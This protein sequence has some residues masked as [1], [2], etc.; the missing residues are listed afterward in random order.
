MIAMPTPNT[1]RWTIE[2]QMDYPLIGEIVPSPD[3]R[4]VLA[5]IREPLMSDDRSEFLTHLYLAGGEGRLRQLTF[6]DQSSY[7]PRWSPDGQHI[8]FV[9][10][11]WGRANLFVMRAAGGEAWALTR[12]DKSDVTNPQ[13]SR[14][15]AQ[16]A[17]LM[18]EPPSQEKEQALKAKDDAQV[19]DD[20][21]RYAHIF[22]VPFVVGPRTPPQARQLTRGRLHVVE[23]DWLADSSG[24][25]FTA[26]PS[27]VA[28]TWPE[29]WLATLALAEGAEPRRSGLVASWA[30]KPLVSP[31]GRWIACVISEGPPHWAFDARAALFALDGGEPRRLHGT[32]DS[33][34]WPVAWD[35]DGQRLYVHEAAGV[36][37]QLLALPIDG[38]PP[39]RVPGP[40]FFT[41]VAISPSGTAVF[42]AEDFDQPNA[43][44]AVDLASGG[45]ARQLAEVSLPPDWPDAPLPRAEVLRWRSAD[46]LE[47]EGIVTYPLAGS[48]PAPLVV[49]VHGGPTGVYQRS[50]LGSPTGYGHICG[51]AERGYATLRVNPRGSS[52]Y[53]RDFRFANMRDW[54]GGDYLD[55]MAGVDTLVERGIADPERLGIMGWSYGGFMTS[56]AITQTRRFKAACIGAPVTNLSSFNG[57]AD[58]PGFIPAYF[59]GEFWDDAELYRRHSP[60]FQ[61]ANANTPAL[62]Q[63]GD[64]DIRVPLSQGREFYNALKRR[65]VPAELVI[66]PRQGHLFEEP[67]LI[68]DV[69]NRTLAW[70]DRY[71]L[72]IDSQPAGE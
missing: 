31:D 6:G 45:P 2:R 60:V 3:G 59:G 19:W 53:G 56:W 9:S 22:V 39:Q 11:R 62:I 15:G 13:W 55:I 52:G 23:H 8:A 57:T 1:Y 24:L 64:A 32:P 34:P 71:V 30:A 72:G 17:F 35:K 33:Q 36:G 50:Y 4:Q 21:H 66:Y 37:S 7:S 12:Y 28:D 63:H 58:I 69:R 49:I 65:G 51:L 40:D 67:R 43:L 54:G 48:G 5:V 18:A 14:D 16:I 70:F 41:S 44:F 47:I 26:Q 46:G 29:T 25:A 61:A 38:G 27:P 68:I 42:V 20:D 10:R